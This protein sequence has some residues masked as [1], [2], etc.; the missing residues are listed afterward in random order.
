MRLIFT[1][2]VLGLLGCPDDTPY[3]YEN[4]QWTCTS[5]DLTQSLEDELNIVQEDID[6]TNGKVR[7]FLQL[8]QVVFCEFGEVEKDIR[9]QRPRTVI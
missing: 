5:R 9:I 1:F 4:N 6:L 8:D 7:V 2:L 3:T